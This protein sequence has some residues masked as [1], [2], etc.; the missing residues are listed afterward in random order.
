MDYIVNTPCGTVQGCAG[1]IPGT[2]AYKGI[3]YAT[4]GRWEYPTQVTSWEGIYDATQYGHCSYQPR[5]FYDEELNEKK[6]FYYNEFRKGASYAYSED[7]LFLNIFTPDTARAG[8]R[9]PVLVYIHGGGYT[10]GC[11]HEKHFDGPVWPG[12]GVIGVTLNYRLGLMGFACLPQLEEEAGHTGNYGLYDQMT[13]IKWVRDNIAAFGGDPE[14]ITIMGQSA[15][16]ASVQLQCQSPLTDGLFTKA[17]MSSGCGMGSMLMG[18]KDSSMPFWQEVMTRCGCR[19]LAE[20]RALPAERLFEAWNRYK[21][22]IKGG[23]TAVFPVV[24]GHFVVAGSEPKDIPYMA[25]STSHDM[26][27]PILQGMAKKWISG[28][29]APSYT[30]FFD[31]MLPG[32]SCGAWHSSDLWYWFGTLPNCWRPMEDKDRG[33][34]AEM[35]GY[36]VNFCRTGDPNGEGLVNWLPSGKGQNKVL[37]M[38]EEAT[39]MG[40]PSMLKLI[41]IMLTNKAVGE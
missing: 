29:K 17:I 40:N 25:G 31:R 9:L 11:G 35:T 15:G 14:N 21:K 16:G 33:L 12:M 26:A 23:G 1:R 20:F 24:D 19:N 39:R 8:D 6:Y 4:A 10:G 28:R 37:H 13:A 36:L 7:C 3:R 30:W 2:A 41:K 38:G 18:K 34:S 32:D 22:E 27:P 5:A